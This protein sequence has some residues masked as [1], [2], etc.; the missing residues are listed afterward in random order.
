MKSFL[1]LGT[2]T[3]YS[4]LA[5]NAFADIEPRAVCPDTRTVMTYSENDAASYSNT[6]IDNNIKIVTTTYD[7]KNLQEFL[8]EYNK[9][10]ERHRKEM[11]KAGASIHLIHGKSVMDDPTWDPSL[12]KTF[13]QRDWSTVSGAGGSPSAK[14]ESK[15]FIKSMNKYCSYALHIDNDKCSKDW[16]REE[17]KE[18]P[19]RMVINQMYPQGDVSFHGSINMVLHE[20]AHGM[21]GI[22]KSNGVSKANNWTRLYNT[23]AIRSYMEIACK[24]AKYCL[25]NKNEAFAELF[26]YYHSCDQTRDHMERNAPVMAKYFEKLSLKNESAMFSGLFSSSPTSSYK[27]STYERSSHGAGTVKKPSIDLLVEFKKFLKNNKKN[28]TEL[29]KGLNP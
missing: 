29:E 8:F 25:D 13:D 3:I 7:L 21:D 23:P 27:K 14:K 22:Y 24:S 1:A 11:L 15:N 28:K 19:A 4:M 5:L 10:P 18:Y 12:M 9:V 26:A 20:Y 2:I 17:P 16:T 6:L